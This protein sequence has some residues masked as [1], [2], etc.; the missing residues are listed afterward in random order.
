MKVIGNEL[1]I[2]GIVASIDRDNIDTDQIIPTEYLKSI[3][4]FGFEDY[5]F[6]GWRYLDDGKLGISKNERKI[7]HEFVLNQEPFTQANILLTRDNFGCGS[8]REH[9]VWALRDFGI[10]VVIASSFGDIFYNNC[11]KNGVLPVKLSKDQIEEIFKAEV[12]EMSVSLDSKKIEFNNT[13]QYEFEV[14]DNLLERIV[15]GLDD[16]DMT[17]KYKND[18]KLFEELRKK[19]KPWIYAD[20]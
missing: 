19:E 2:K 3:K 6:D 9:A 11:F 17:L 8:S 16:V 12:G 18:I 7:N 5:L 14:E 4:K 20:E 13:Y 15:L 1:Q 10:R